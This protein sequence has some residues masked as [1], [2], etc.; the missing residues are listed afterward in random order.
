[1][2]HHH[3]QQFY[4]QHPTTAS[5]DFAVILLTLS[6]AQLASTI[7]DFLRSDENIIDAILPEA[8]LR[9][10]PSV[11]DGSFI[12][13][14][15][16]EIPIDG[17]FSLPIGLPLTGYEMG[18][19]ERLNYPP[20]LIISSFSSNGS[21]SLPIEPVV[22]QE[23][24]WAPSTPQPPTPTTPTTA[25]GQL[26]LSDP[27]GHSFLHQQPQQ[28]HHHQVCTIKTENLESKSLQQMRN[29]SK[30]RPGPYDNLKDPSGK[31]N[32]ELV[33]YLNFKVLFLTMTKI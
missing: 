20:P 15:L 22:K 29:A 9:H 2:N 14:S 8:N 12:D 11:S 32:L 7:S 26:G 28:Q 25:L 1:M 17:T 33:C 24:C 5:G 18:Q 13:P 31:I 27:F 16:D 30:R 23:P 3:Q 19:N 10:S 4:H 6:I 21:L